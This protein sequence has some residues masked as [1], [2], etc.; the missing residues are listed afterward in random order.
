MQSVNTDG[1]IFSVRGD[2]LTT[3]A[4]GGLLIESGGATLFGGLYVSGGQTITDGGLHVED[5]DVNIQNGALNVRENGAVINSDLQSVSALVAETSDNN[6][7]ATVVN[8]RTSRDP[9]DEY[10]FI[11]FVSATETIGYLA[12]DG[13]KEETVVSNNNRALYHMR[14]AQESGGNPS[15]VSD[16]EILRHIEFQGYGGTGYQSSSAIRAV[17]DETIPSDTAMGGSLLFYTSDATTTSLEQRLLI[18]AQGVLTIG[19][20]P[21]ERIIVT[22]GVEGTIAA[23]DELHLD[24]TNDIELTAAGGDISL[25]ASSS[26]IGAAQAGEIDLDA[27]LTQS[28][29]SG[30][31]ATL[32]TTD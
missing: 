20:T 7:D 12:G 31:Q 17:V 13:F 2:G 14:R 8:V 1:T 16:G 26:I 19:N 25:I 3:I 30:G 11:E 10:N 27:L 18:D 28:Y 24:A 9:S 21:T 29:T 23:Q 22:P 4:R 15:A 6:F 32:E 5:G